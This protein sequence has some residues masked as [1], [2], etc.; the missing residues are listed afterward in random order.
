MADLSDGGQPTISIPINPTSTTGEDKHLPVEI[1]AQVI[2]H[3]VV[4]GA[5]FSNGSADYVN[6]ETIRSLL[7]TSREIQS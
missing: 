1:I 2:A 7:K 4:D 5:T 6:S 3:V